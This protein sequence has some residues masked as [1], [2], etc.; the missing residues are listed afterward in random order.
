MQ[1]THSAG[2]DFDFDKHI[3]EMEAQNYEEDVKDHAEYD[4]VGNDLHED[5]L[6]SSEADQAATAQ[7]AHPNASPRRLREPQN[8][9]NLLSMPG[10]FDNMRDGG[11]E[12]RLHFYKK[13]IYWN[14]GRRGTIWY[15]KAP[16]VSGV[17]PM[18][19][20]TQYFHEHSGQLGKNACL[21]HAKPRP[22]LVFTCWVVRTQYTTH[23]RIDNGK[24]KYGDDWE[25]SFRSRIEEADDITATDMMQHKDDELEG[26]VDYDILDMG[27]GLLKHPKEKPLPG[28][29]Q[30]MVLLLGNMAS[31]F[32]NLMTPTSEARRDVR[33]HDATTSRLSTS[34]TPTKE[35]YE[36]FRTFQLSSPFPQDEEF[37]SSKLTP[38]KRSKKGEKGEKTR[39]RKALK[40]KIPDG[41]KNVVSSSML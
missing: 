20:I 12:V 33:Y 26:S 23:C 17:I 30:L 18:T 41:K 10:E 29:G 27:K 1:D 15:S 22:G 31:G 7:L 36:P 16:A 2:M 4:F 5:L 34:I 38:S 35:R 24:D 6:A 3:K 8:L 28:L 37:S 21:L 32:P 13:M 9:Q 11:S 14:V 39:A 19:H 40:V 25:E